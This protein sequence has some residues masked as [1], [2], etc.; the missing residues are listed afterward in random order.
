[1]DFLDNLGDVGR[2][3]GLLSLLRLEGSPSVMVVYWIIL[4]GGDDGEVDCL[5]VWG[6]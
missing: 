5:S 3:Y 2:Q 4:E 6:C 1:M